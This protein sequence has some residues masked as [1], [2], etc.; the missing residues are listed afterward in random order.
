MIHIFINALAASAGGGLTYVRNVI[1]AIA[2]RVDV[3]ATVLVSPELRR[4][5]G[6]WANVEL[7]ETP[8]RSGS[9]S[10]LWF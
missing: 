9:A 3:Q 5:L 7:L 1:P 2:A 4:E 10:R 6:A 8:N